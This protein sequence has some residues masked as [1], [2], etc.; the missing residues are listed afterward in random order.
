MNFNN[1][2]NIHFIGIG[3]IGVS[4]LARLALQ[5]EKEVTGSDASE[6][7]ILTDLR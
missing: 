3:G 6:S 5:E 1:A 7:E 2:D 4:A